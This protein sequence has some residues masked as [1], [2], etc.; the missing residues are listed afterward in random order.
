M[1]SVLVFPFVAIRIVGGGAAPG[2]P[3]S[4]QEY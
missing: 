2:P 1:L 3:V 4:D